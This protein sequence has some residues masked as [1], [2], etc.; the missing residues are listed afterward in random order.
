[1]EID[2]GSWREGGREKLEEVGVEID[3]GSWRE[4][5]REEL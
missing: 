3:S 4:G 2:S 5:G 1:M